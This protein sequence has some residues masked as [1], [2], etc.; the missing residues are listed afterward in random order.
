MIPPRPSSVIPPRLSSVIPPR[1]SSV[2]LA[3]LGP[4]GA[5]LA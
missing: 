1:P 5:T 3:W 4:P 2:T